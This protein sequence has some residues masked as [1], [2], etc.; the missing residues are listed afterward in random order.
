MKDKKFLILIVLAI[1]W[2]L[3]FLGTAFGEIK[4]NP[5]VERL[6]TVIILVWG[7]YWTLSTVF[8]AKKDEPSKPTEEPKQP[9]NKKS[10][11]P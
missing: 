9:S 10:P 7:G 4:L 6:L 1:G 3:L 5:N 8:W 2:L 11:K